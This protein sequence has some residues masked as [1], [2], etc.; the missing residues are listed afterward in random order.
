MADRVQIENLKEAKK[1]CRDL[2]DKDLSKALRAANK[3]AAMVVADAA[4]LTVP[5][6]SGKLKRSIGA[7]ATLDSAS[8]KAGT[9]A[10][11][12]YAGAIHYGWGR[13]NI[14]PQPFLMR[15]LRK[16]TANIQAIYGRNIDEVVKQINTALGS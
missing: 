11:V 6:R 3:S 7:S 8:V 4:K 10:R 13:R 12:P 16:N 15:A 14:R 2:K 5:E 1:A 9:A